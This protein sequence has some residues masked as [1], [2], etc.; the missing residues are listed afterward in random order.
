MVNEFTV[1]N[2]RKKRTG[3]KMK[4]AMLQKK[5]A[6]GIM[7][8]IGIF[9]LTACGEENET[10]PNQENED[11]IAVQYLGVSD[12]VLVD[13][14]G[15]GVEN[16]ST[17]DGKEVILS[18]VYKEKFLGFD[19]EL[20]VMLSSDGVVEYMLYSLNGEKDAVVKAIN[21]ALKK[22]K[23]DEVEE[24]NASIGYKAIWR[25]DGYIYTMIAEE[26]QIGVAV[27]KE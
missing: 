26:N 22:E 5:W 1:K 7:V 11:A 24:E 4:I 9:L 2:K 10:A 16:K 25:Q 12:E 23:P 6:L 27:I 15:N 20:T 18:R 8:F 21:E 13:A 14:K 17:V 3:Y 19:S